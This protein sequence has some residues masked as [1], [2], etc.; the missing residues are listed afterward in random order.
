[1]LRILVLGDQLGDYID[2]DIQNTSIMGLVRQ[3]IDSDAQNTSI[4]G[5]V[6]R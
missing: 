4:M 2:S 6:T 3:S 5:S 1:M